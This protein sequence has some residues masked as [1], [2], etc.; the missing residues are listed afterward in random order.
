MDPNTV[1]QYDDMPQH[2]P[3]TWNGYG[4]RPLW[5]KIPEEEGN[6]EGAQ[7]AGDV[8]HAYNHLNHYDE[9]I[10]ISSSSKST[11]VSTGFSVKKS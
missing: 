6:F 5:E 10:V 4:P 8:H 9:I 2:K 1:S 3:F 7:I 11:S